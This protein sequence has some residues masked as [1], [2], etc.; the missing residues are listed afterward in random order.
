MEELNKDLDELQKLLTN[1]TRQ[2]AKKLLTNEIERI[3]KEIETLKAKTAAAATGADTNN[4]A[5]SRASSIL[6]TIKITTYAWDQ[7]EKF[8]KLY[9]TVP[10]ATT[11]QGQ[12]GRVQFDVQ[13]KSVDVNATD[14]AGKNYFFTVKGLLLPVLREGSEFKVKNGEI[15]LML[16]KKWQDWHNHK[17]MTRESFWIL[18]SRASPCFTV[19]EYWAFFVSGRVVVIIPPTA[20]IRQSTFPNDTNLTSSLSINASVTPKAEAID[21]NFT[22]L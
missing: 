2:R 17:W 13:T 9:V 1:A 16:K 12:E 21:F 8:L 4:G 6:P 20:S 5:G 18:L 15:L 7:S 14:I 19:V 11:G 3:Q 10:G 22:E